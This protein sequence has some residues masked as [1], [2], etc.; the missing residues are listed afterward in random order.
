M[1]IRD[2]ELWHTYT[3]VIAGPTAPP[4]VLAV[5]LVGDGLLSSAITRDG[6][7]VWSTGVPERAVEVAQIGRASDG[8]LTCPAGPASAAPTGF[9][10]ASL[11]QAVLFRNSEVLLFPQHTGLPGPYARGL[12]GMCM[13]GSAGGGGHRF[14][15]YPMLTVYEHGVVV[16]SLRV[17]GAPGAAIPFDR[18][19]S[20]VAMLNRVDIGSVMVPPAVALAGFRSGVEWRAARTPWARRRI[21]ADIQRVAAALDDATVAG[22]TE[23]PF[24]VDHAPLDIATPGAPVR[25][26]TDFGGALLA[27]AAYA[28]GDRRTGAALALRGEAPSC[29]IEYPFTGR[30]HLYLI[31]FDGQQLTAA[32]NEAVHGDA[33]GRLIGG[34]PEAAPVGAGRE[35]LPPNT[36]KMGDMGWYATTSGSLT[37]WS[38]FGIHGRETGRAADADRGRLVYEQHARAEM[39]EYGYALHRRL[40]LRTSDPAGRLS[41]VLNAQRAVL[42]LEAATDEVSHFRDVRNFV[43][44]G[45]SALG[46]PALR[47]RARDGLELRRDEAAAAE[48]ERSARWTNGITL[49]FGFLAVSALAKDVLDPLARWAKWSVPDGPAG[50]LLLVFVACA[51]VGAALV[52]A[53]VA[54]ARTRARR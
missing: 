44:A 24:P 48:A 22:E 21:I 25:R 49:V 35:L 13:V 43:L 27:A 17:V 9:A 37:V 31:R 45:W 15:V 10:S 14:R 6:F 34:L 42:A 3:A 23:G 7:A 54:A 41:D 29:G 30:P 12:M 28:A 52:L 16:V 26:L 51:I 19:V 47:A 5:R 50:S 1:I 33:F 8:R 20:D 2:W 53:R 18:F 36:R 38:A 32:E 40:Y 39:L 4:E 46:V 11:D